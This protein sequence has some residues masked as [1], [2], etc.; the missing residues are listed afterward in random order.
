MHY[1][2]HTHT[3]THKL[4]VF[5]QITHHFHLISQNSSFLGEQISPHAKREREKPI[6][7]FDG[8]ERDFFASV[9]RGFFIFFGTANNF[10]TFKEKLHF[11]LLSMGSISISHY[12]YKTEQCSSLSI[13][14][15][16]LTSNRLFF[17]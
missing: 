17:C 6:Q 8:R 11:P 16:Q 2:T 13:E 4:I 10:S 12:I 3:H 1:F 15:V 5:H 9:Y 7:R 14:N